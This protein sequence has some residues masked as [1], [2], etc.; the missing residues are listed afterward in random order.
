MSFCNIS[1]QSLYPFVLPELPYSK[2]SFL[3]YFTGETFDYHHGQHHKAYVTNLNN[4]L[5]SEEDLQKKNLEELIILSSG[6]NQAIFNN[7]AQ[8]WNH[9]FFFNSIKPGGSVLQGA[10]LNQ[11]LSDFGTVENFTAEFKKNAMAQFGSGWV[12]LVVRGGHIEII[13][14]ANAETPIS[15]GLQPIIACDVWEHAY[16]ID[17]RNRRLDYVTVFIEHMINWEFANKNF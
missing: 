7:A 9:T 3:P 1:N 14:T 16:Y 2:D 15:M 5:K 10:I 6:S 12:W 13:K 17:Y 4:L 11:I 8:I